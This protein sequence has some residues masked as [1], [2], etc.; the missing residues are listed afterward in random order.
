[1]KRQQKN[2]LSFRNGFTFIEILLVTGLI[3]LL[4]VF[5]FASLSQFRIASA[6]DSGTEKVFTVVE[7][8]R[9]STLVGK[10]ESPYGVHFASSSLILFK[11]ETYTPGDPENEKYPLDSLLEI[12]QVSFSGG[13]KSA[14]FDR[15]TGATQDYGTFVLQAKQSSSRKIIFEI[16]KTGNITQ[17]Q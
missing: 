4:S 5:V 8:A 13:G 9:T 7:S 3:A 15:L 1:M 2:N 14:V 11:G 12:D 6:L 10:D 16:Q 17:F